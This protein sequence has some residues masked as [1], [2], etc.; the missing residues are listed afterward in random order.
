[1]SSATE[2]P[3]PAV[4]SAMR[5]EIAPLLSAIDARP[6]LTED[7]FRLYR[8]RA[9][10]HSVM[11]AVLGDGAT[12]AERG[13]QRLLEI[14]MPD[15]LLLIGFA[16]GLSS[17]LP[18]GALVQAATVQW[19]GDGEPIHAD[20]SPL[21]GVDRGAV[22]SAA[23]VLWAA[24]SKQQAWSALGAPAR[25]VVDLESWALVRRLQEAAIPWT[26]LRAVSDA[27]NETL[28][29]D[30]SALTDS[31]GRL[32]RSRVI[33]SALR[34]P[35]TLAGLLRLRSRGRACARRLVPV[36]VDWLTS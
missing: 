10:D 34:R 36:A 8:G 32:I 14:I 22:V 24:D 28:P 17:D 2:G 18:S 11:A 35:S 21:A 1:M 12:V 20:D 3:T 31:D 6:L 29:L 9:G 4:V 30:F 19:L 16:G 27:A 25:C 15:R 26:V 23:R 7:T 5:E 33:L 13:L